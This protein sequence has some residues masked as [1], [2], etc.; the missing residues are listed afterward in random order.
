MEKKPFE[1]CGVRCSL[2]PRSANSAWASVR[3]MS[4]GGLAVEQREQHGDQAAHD[5]GVAVALE[6]EDRRAVRHRCGS[7]AGEPDLAGAAAHLVGVGAQRFGQRRQRRARARSGSGSGL[8]SRRAA[9]SPSVCLQSTWNTEGAR[10]GFTPRSAC[11]AGEAQPAERRPSLSIWSQALLAQGV[12][13]RCRSGAAARRP[14]RCPCAAPTG[15]A[16]PAACPWTTVCRAGRCCWRWCSAGA[17]A[18]SR[19]PGAAGAD[20]VAHEACA[21]LGLLEEGG[22]G[23]PQPSAQ[24]A[25]LRSQNVVARS[26]AAVAVV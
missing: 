14:V 9:Q 25:G 24:V 4:L 11:E 13:H 20:E 8:P 22:P 15:R 5:V 19:R 17:A 16:T 23:A 18:A 1:R 7:R 6:V 3:R 2:S 12:R 10:S 21:E 26:T